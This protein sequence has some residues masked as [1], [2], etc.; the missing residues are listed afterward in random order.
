MNELLWVLLLFVLCWVFYLI[1]KFVEKQNWKGKIGEIRTDAIER[2]RAV[3]TGNFSEQLAPYLPGF[4]YSPTEVR[5]IGK[6]VDFIVFK[7]LDNKAPEEVIFVEVKSGQAEL[8][9]PERKLRDAI[10][11]KKVS[12]EVY[13]IPKFGRKLE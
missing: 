8:S 3:L 2:S 6:P 1:G 10:N 7:G 13:R 12:F 5:F 4:K 9:T 11:D